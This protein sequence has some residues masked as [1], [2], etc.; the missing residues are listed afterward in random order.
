M[1]EVTFYIEPFWQFRHIK[2]N[3]H[4]HTSRILVPVPGKM[5]PGESRDRTTVDTTN[6][7]HTSLCTHS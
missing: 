4:L 6:L 7:N 5:H 2:S 3:K 1:S